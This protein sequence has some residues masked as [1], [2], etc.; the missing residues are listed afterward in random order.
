MTTFLKLGTAST[1]LAGK[2]ALVG[3]YGDSLEWNLMLDSTSLWG[4]WSS[5]NGNLLAIEAMGMIPSTGPAY[6]FLFVKREDNHLWYTQPLASDGWEDLGK[7]ASDVEVDKSMGA[8]S[9]GGSPTVIMTGTD[10]NLW[11]RW[12]AGDNWYWQNLGMPT[13]SNVDIVESMGTLYTKDNGKHYVFVKGSD[14]NLWSMSWTNE[15]DTTWECIGTPS[16]TAIEMSIGAIAGNSGNIAYTFLKGDDGNIWVTYLSNNQRIWANLE[17]PSDI[18]IV[19]SMGVISL[20]G[21]DLDV[22]VLGGNGCLW[23]VTYS[24]GSGGAWENLGTPTP[25]TMIIESLG[26]TIINNPQRPLVVVLG[27]DNKPYGG[28]I[29]NNSWTWKHLTQ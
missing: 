3:G 8:Y 15:Q 18:E 19:Q 2:A 9:Y 29:E 7:P 4:D 24:T 11:V 14:G 1:N 12:L 21:L 13:S 22:Y 28:T 26:T 10:G 17:G 20:N 27:S 25:D 16:N 6:P 5:D 23:K